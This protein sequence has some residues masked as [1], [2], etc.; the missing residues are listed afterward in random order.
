MD[1]PSPYCR[2]AL[3]L[4]AWT[5]VFRCW[6]C[7]TAADVVWPPALEDI[8]QV[9]ALRP[10]EATRNWQVG[11][12]V[13]D[14]VRENLEHGILPTERE[15][16]AHRGGPLLRVEAGRVLTGHPALTGSAMPTPRGF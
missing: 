11:E 13:L 3:L 6:D 4:P 9:L 5:P 14:L 15:L 8:V 2:S 12:D 1:C 7:G 16:V 10:N